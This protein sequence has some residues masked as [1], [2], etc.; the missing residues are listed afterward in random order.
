MVGNLIGQA[1]HI[2]GYFGLSVVAVM[3]FVALLH[4][5]KRRETAMIRW[6]LLAMWGGA[7]LGMALYGINEE[8][9]VAA[10]QLHLIFIPLMTCYGLAYL[11]VQWNRLDIGIPF[12][13]AGFLALLYFLCALPMIS[14]TL[15][16]VKTLVHWPPYFPG[17]IS[18]LHDWMK[19][20]EVIASDMPWAIAW[21]ADRRSLWLPESPKIF[22][23]I[24]DYKLLGTPINALYL[25]PISGT[26][27]RF[28]DIVKGEYRDWA[29]LIGRYHPLDKFP[30]QW[31][32]T[33][34]GLESE[35]IFLSDHDRERASSAP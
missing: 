33:A 7:V 5:F 31:Q 10:N 24:S 12:A 4:P 13:R 16:P 23:G 32:S 22:S 25:T 27:N 11:L 17:A 35:C 28:R 34:L 21:Y 18:V 9:G 15:S 26:E 30:L 6:M 19:P 8:L 1:G 3:F 29:P 20:E 14:R 2:F